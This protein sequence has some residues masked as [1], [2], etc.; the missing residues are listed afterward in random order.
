MFHQE[1]AGIAKPVAS[2]L[3]QIDLGHDGGRELAQILVATGAAE[4]TEC[5]LRDVSPGGSPFHDE[6]QFIRHGGEQTR[7]GSAEEWR[8]I[9]DH[10]VVALPQLTQEAWRLL[11]DK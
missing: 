9:N 2:V 4:Q 7:F 1:L 10:A 3:L 6:Q 5:V 8:S 11:A